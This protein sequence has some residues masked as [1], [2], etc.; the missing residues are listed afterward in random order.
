MDRRKNGGFRGGNSKLFG[1]LGSHSWRNILIQSSFSSNY[2][3]S[4]FDRSEAP[5]ALADRLF[6]EGYGKQIRH[7]RHSFTSMLSHPYSKSVCE[8]AV[9]IRWSADGIGT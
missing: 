5:A 8:T 1:G 9:H 2:L 3:A 4:R 7:G 6:N